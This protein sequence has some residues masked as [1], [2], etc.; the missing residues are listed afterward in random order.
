MRERERTKL[1]KLRAKESALQAR[2][3]A[4]EAKER[5][6]ARRQDTRRKI[7]VGAAVLH[8]CEGD[9][10]AQAK[11]LQLL[12]RFLSKPQDRQLFGLAVDTADQVPL[13]PEDKPSETFSQVAA[14]PPAPT[15]SG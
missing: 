14:R 6:E 8:E 2:I 13:S 4:L 3:K 15:V 12:D 7:L 11:L 1:E 9:E 5:D 10:A